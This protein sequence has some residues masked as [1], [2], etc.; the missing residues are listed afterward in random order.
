MAHQS[1]CPLRQLHSWCRWTWNVSQK[2]PSLH[3]ERLQVNFCCLP[4]KPFILTD[5]EY[6]ASNAPEARDARAYAVNM[7]HLIKLN[8]YVLRFPAVVLLNLPKS[9]NKNRNK[10]LPLSKNRKLLSFVLLAIL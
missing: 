2:G 1:S 7:T 10:R 8:K 4:L 3:L 5:S 6:A 9:N